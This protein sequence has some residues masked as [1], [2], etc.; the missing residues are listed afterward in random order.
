MADKAIS[1]LIS[2][3]RITATDLFVLQQDNTAK[4]L[5]GQVLLNWLTAAADGH[6][7]IQSW[8]PLKTEGLVKTVRVTLADQTYIDI[9]VVDGRGVEDVRKIKTE[10]LVDTY[11]IIYNDGPPG[12]FAITNGEK[13][14][15]GD[16]ADI[17][18]RY[19]SQK[20]TAESH[21][22]GELPD[23]W[24]G[25]ASGHL[26]SAPTDWQAY[27]WYQW[28]GA[29]GDKGDPATLVSSN[30]EYQVSSSGTVVPS[31]S[32]SSS[33]LVVPQGMYLWTKIT[34]TF[35]TGSPVISYSVSR[36]GLDGSGSVSSVA[37]IS[38]D[39]NGNVPLTAGD[40]GAVPSTGGD[41]TGELRMNGQPISGLNAPT[42]NDQ[43]ANMGFVNQQV[44][45]AAPR[46]LLDNSD[47][48]NPVN[49]RGQ[50]S[51]LGH[52]Y[53]IDRWQ[54][55]SSTTLTVMDDFCRLSGHYNLWQ[56]VP[57]TLK[58]GK[59]YTCAARIKA[60][61]G[62]RDGWLLVEASVDGTR[63]AGWSKKI[64]DWTIAI[65]NFTPDSDLE[66]A[67]IQFTN[68]GDTS[69]A[70]DIEWVALYEGEYTAETLPEYQP[71][72]YGAELLECQRYLQRFRTAD[73]RKTY[74]DDFRPTMRETAEG[75][76]ST[77]DQEINGVTYYFASAEL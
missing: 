6:G 28:K 16:N 47:F 55:N 23:A 68:S 17:W 36:T 21:S 42:A 70:T 2:T 33:V 35:N 53:S 15:K 34:N 57:V 41:M 46:N 65:V 8:V 62:I 13:G 32:W 22:F 26:A 75:I 49:Q 30:V 48:R 31:G 71:K 37:N 27:T 9:D 25:V 18:I 63:L 74:C 11:Q 64:S 73:L 52:S 58:A 20:P 69:V 72:G 67:V 50:T 1:E 24:I 7:G 10:G 45:K 76:V 44:R 60:S 39:G 61:E 29:K 38:P 56:I 66:A 43:A 3:E 54:V 19:A 4:K 14:D 77:F 5:S 51:Y 59:T 12:T 40:V